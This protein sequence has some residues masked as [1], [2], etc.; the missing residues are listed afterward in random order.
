MEEKR[1]TAGQE[2]FQ[3]LGNAIYRGADCCILVFDVTLSKSFEHLDN[4]FRE[5]ILQANIHDSKNYP[6]IILANKIDKGERI[7]SE[8]Q[9]QRW[10]EEHGNVLG[11]E[12]SA[13]ESTNVDSAFLAAARLALANSVHDSFAKE[14]LESIDI[15]STKKPNE[16][17]CCNN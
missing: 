13:K 15:S 6:F 1:D 8:Q 11:F 3:S 5:F 2:R 10:R 12:T 16:R 17:V 14:T 7:V 4:W 9:H